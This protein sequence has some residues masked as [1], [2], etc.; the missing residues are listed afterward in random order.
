MRSSPS[1]DHSFGSALRRCS[2]AHTRL[3]IAKEP[4]GPA[5]EQPFHEASV[6]DDVH[7]RE[8][9]G[10]TAFVSAMDSGT[11][12]I[13]KFLQDAALSGVRLAPGC[14]FKRIPSPTRKNR[15]S[16]A[17]ARLRRRVQ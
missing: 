5:P 6:N 13:T 15:T 7:R 8:H 14:S 1:I 12:R 10:I 4:C 16:A 3:P 9:F 17:G 11:G 2:K